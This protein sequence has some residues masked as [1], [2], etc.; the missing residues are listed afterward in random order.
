MGFGRRLQWHVLLTP[1]PVPLLC[2]VFTPTPS[3]ARAGPEGVASC[4]FPQNLKNRAQMLS[5]QTTAAPEPRI[6]LNPLIIHGA[7]N[8]L[9]APA[10]LPRSPP[11]RSQGLG[12]G[13]PGGGGPASCK[14]HPRPSPRRPRLPTVASSRAAR[15]EDPRSSLSQDPPRCTPPATNI[16]PFHH[17]P[18]PLGSGGPSPPGPGPSPGCTHPPAPLPREGP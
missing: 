1:T 18:P 2:P 8:S 4:S 3:R 16:G 12:V 5:S 10:P 13:L 6:S 14:A 17:N 9:V 11:P 15:H 7:P